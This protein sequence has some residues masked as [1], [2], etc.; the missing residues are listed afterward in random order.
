MRLKARIYQF[1]L[2]LTQGKPIRV[3][4][5]S[6]CELIYCPV[7]RIELVK[8][9]IERSNKSTHARTHAHTHTHQLITQPVCVIVNH[10][11][12]IATESLRLRPVGS[13]AVLA[14]AAAWWPNS[15]RGGTHIHTCTHHTCTLQPSV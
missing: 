5:I 4:P 13:P 1:N 3:F 14:N 12:F 2:K 9:P 7:G 15:D 11:V 8:L 6:V 10:S